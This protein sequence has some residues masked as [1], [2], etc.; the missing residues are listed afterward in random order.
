MTQH[1]EVHEQGQYDDDGFWY[2]PIIADVDT[3]EEADQIAEE[4]DGI[5]RPM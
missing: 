2:E 3:Q 5:V 4:S 1:Y